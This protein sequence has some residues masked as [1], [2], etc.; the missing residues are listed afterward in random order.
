MILVSGHRAR[1]VDVWQFEVQI[2]K[3]DAIFIVIVC[4]KSEV[5]VE[6]KVKLIVYNTDL[7]RSHR[8]I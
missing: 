5:K 3:V 8:C 4:T 7:G 1:K 2:S 6:V